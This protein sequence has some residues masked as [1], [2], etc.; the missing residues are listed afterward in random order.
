[1]HDP[2]LNVSRNDS[3]AY[4]HGYRDLTESQREK[5]QGFREYV[6]VL[7]W[8]FSIYSVTTDERRSGALSCNKVEPQ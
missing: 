4:I 1:M 5:N 7:I 6:T 3:Y 8:G 2:L